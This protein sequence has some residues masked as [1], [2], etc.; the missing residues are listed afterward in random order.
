MIDET[1]WGS[2]IKYL[3][4][5]YIEGYSTAMEGPNVQGIPISVG[6]GDRQC[7]VAT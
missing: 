5:K 1:S 2:D 7:E 6:E 3:L 4:R